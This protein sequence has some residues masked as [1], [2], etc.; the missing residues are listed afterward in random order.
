M[1]STSIAPVF[2]GDPGTATDPAWAWEAFAEATV[3]GQP[4]AGQ[5]GRTL[6]RAVR[7]R[8]PDRRKGSITVMLRLAAAVFLAAFLLGAVF[9]QLGAAAAHASAVTG[10]YAQDGAACSAVYHFHHEAALPVYAYPWRWAYDHAWHMAMSADPVERRDIHA[11]L[12]TGH[13]WSLVR[14]DCVADDWAA[15]T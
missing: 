13:G 6:V 7:V 1:T 3:T 11:Y 2:P 15:Q 8:K 12:S 4:E 10:T 5:M 9:P 14:L